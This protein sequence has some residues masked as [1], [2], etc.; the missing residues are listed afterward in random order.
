MDEIEEIADRFR[1]LSKELKATVRSKKK[2][3]DARE[4]SIIR[5][6]HRSDESPRENKSSWYE[7]IKDYLVRR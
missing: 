5:F 3:D 7:G 2:M 1:S 4:D 6:V